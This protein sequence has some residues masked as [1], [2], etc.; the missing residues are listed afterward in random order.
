MSINQSQLS[1]PLFSPRSLLS[2]CIWGINTF[3]VRLCVFPQW[4]PHDLGSP[5]DILCSVSSWVSHCTCPGVV[6]K[7][8]SNHTEIL[9]RNTVALKGCPVWGEG[10]QQW[11]V[12]PVDGRQPVCSGLFFWGRADSPSMRRQIDSVTFL[13]GGCCSANSQRQER[14]RPFKTSPKQ[15]LTDL[16]SVCSSS[17]VGTSPEGALLELTRLQGNLRNPELM[18]ISGVGQRFS[19]LRHSHAIH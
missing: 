7:T 1:C 16:G 10:R 8:S 2:W 18:T 5:A 14:S 12:G 19:P 6:N 15:P 4:W 11:P 9:N 13:G 17:Q 3:L